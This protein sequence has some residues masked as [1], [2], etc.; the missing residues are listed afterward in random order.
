MQQE[1]ATSHALEIDVPGLFQ[2]LFMKM[3]EG[4]A[5]H[6]VVCDGAGRPTNYRVIEVNSVY[7]R[8]AGRRRADL[9][10]KLANEAYQEHEPPH[11]GIYGK[12]ALDGHSVRFEEYLPALGRCFEVSVA[13]MGQG[14]FSTVL[15]DVTDRH[16]HDTVSREGEGFLERSQIIGRLGSFRLEV[17]TGRWVGSR[18]LDDLFGLEPDFVKDVAG[19]F[20][21]V[22][23]HDQ[24]EV[25]RYLTE[26][27]LQK[28][29]PFDRRYRIL[30]HCDGSLRWVH[31]RAEPEK[32]EL[33]T[34]RYLIGTVQDITDSVRKEQALESKFE[35]LDRIFSLTLE[36]LS[37]SSADGRL[38]RV[39][40]AWERVLGWSV[41]ELEGSQYV[42]L[43]HSDDLSSTLR[44]MEELASGRDVI[45][46][47][48]RC[49]C[50]DGSYR[51]LEWRSVPAG[52]AIYSGAR[53]VSERERSR[54]E[55]H[56]LEQQLRQ[57]QKME[58]VGLLAGGVAHDFN[59]LLTVILGCTDELMEMVV[60][61]DVSRGLLSEVDQAGRRAAELTRQLLAFS[62]QQ[63]LQPR[64]VDLNEIVLG[65]TSMLRRM[66]GE[67]V[68]LVWRPGPTVDRIFADPGQ[69]EQIIVNLAV[70]ARDA[71][72]EGGQLLLESY[73]RATLPA[74]APPR[75]EPEPRGYVVLAVHDT[76]V[77]MDDATRERI[78]EPF[79]STKG[80]L[81]TGL[82]LSTVY[83]IVTQSGGQVAVM[84]EPGQ[85]TTF[86]VYLPA[87]AATSL[88]RNSAGVLGGQRLGGHESVLLVEDEP[89]VRRILK[90]ILTGAGYLVIEAGN[91]DEAM[92]LNAERRGDVDVLLTDVVMPGKTGRQLA[93]RLLLERPSLRVIYMSGYAP[94]EVPA[95]AGLKDRHAFIQKPIRPVQL[96]SKLREVLDCLQAM[97]A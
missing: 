80:E 8:V 94:S 13:S 4:A 22:H 85:G 6:Q 71:M 35:E 72:P 11:L 7:E 15:S 43:I 25:A 50:K 93:E 68:E 91:A 55:R 83:G 51:Y 82:G 44:S 42:D 24:E 78:F 34:T 76:G 14:Y 17:A 36:M 46:F 53:D 75:N 95:L 21:L 29:V 70:N 49:L 61:D 54:L 88:R 81:G 10:G 89:S 90:K 63:V 86:E 39:N 73:N 9:I 23:P 32:D 28:G 67:R 33:G 77:G 60:R 37:I 26:E 74:G 69:L 48:N 5:L 84:S 96:L 47:T 57:S 19:W 41:E 87:A 18:G 59:N 92:R 3:D 97:S 12:V 79:F 30:R 52:G 38:M 40:A 1:P 20:G 31:A 64:L 56:R 58:S 65:V 2:A 66:L 27:V 45:D 62:R 16:L